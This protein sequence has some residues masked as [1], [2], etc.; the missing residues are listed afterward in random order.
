M[1]TK[2]SLNNSVKGAGTEG[3]GFSPGSCPMGKQHRPTH[4]TATA[5]RNW[6]KEDNK[7]ATLCY[8]QA[9]EGLNIGCSKRMHQY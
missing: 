6:S 5:R 1:P 3:E 7:M 2:K 8:L 4:H 9:K